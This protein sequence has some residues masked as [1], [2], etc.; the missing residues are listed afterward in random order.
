MNSKGKITKAL[1]DCY[2]DREELQSQGDYD[3][4]GELKIQTLEWVL[5]NVLSDEIE[6]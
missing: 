4:D 1:S 5:F 6:Q 2:A 3:Y